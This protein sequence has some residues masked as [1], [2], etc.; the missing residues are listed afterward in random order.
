VTSVDG[1]AAAYVCENFTCQA[2]VTD[3]AK[4]RELLAR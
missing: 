1:K 4:L 2:P 3:P